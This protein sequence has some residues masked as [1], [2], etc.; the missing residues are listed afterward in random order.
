MQVGI[1]GQKASLDIGHTFN[2]VTEGVLRQFFE[3]RYED[4]L[5]KDLH[6]QVF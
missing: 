3:F 5:L 6:N 1:D 2:H 4:S